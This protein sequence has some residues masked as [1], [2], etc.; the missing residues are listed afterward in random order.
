MEKDRELVGET[1]LVTVTVLEKVEVT[2]LVTVTV[3]ETD[4]TT[5]PERD[6]LVDTPLP[7]DAVRLKDVPADPVEA[8]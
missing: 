2:V 4:V 3:F 8:V 6:E 5:T 1:V 7:I